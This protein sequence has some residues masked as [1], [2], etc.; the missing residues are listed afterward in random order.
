MSSLG[1]KNH[2]GR[3]SRKGQTIPVLDFS[4]FAEPKTSIHDSWSVFG[5]VSFFQ[6]N[7]CQFDISL[8]RGNADDWECLYD[9][10]TA[11]F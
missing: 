8:K 9:P 1:K 5:G 2:Q 6:N 7:G 3:R 4:H 11:M 10:M